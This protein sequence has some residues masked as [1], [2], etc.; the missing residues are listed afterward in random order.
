MNKKQQVIDTARDLF[1]R[2]GYRRVSMD[3]I[4]RVSG[5]TKRTIYS[6]FKDKN[7]LIKF[8]LYD[9]LDHMRKKIEVID[10]EDISFTLRISKTIMMLIEYRTNSKLLNAFYKDSGKERVKISDE[11]IG[12][13]DEAFQHEI[14]IRL[15]K[16]ISDGHI[17]DCDTDITAFIIYKIYI[18]LMFEW[19][20]PLD[21]DEVTTRIMNILE[22]GLFRQGDILWQNTEGIVK[23]LN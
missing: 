5:V 21:K 4:A 22:T 1:G 8:F 12:I 20:K 9:E 13:L 19:N 14:K 16:A 2:Y 7:D 23:R 10:K 3:E 15:E 6:Y 17:K 18:A 11:C